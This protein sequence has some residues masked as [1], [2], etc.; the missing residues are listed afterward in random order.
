[1]YRIYKI[2]AD[3]VV[4]FAA[5][6]L[7]KYLRTM[8]PEYGE[9]S[10]E[11]DPDAK[12][13]FR[14][15]LLEDFGLPNEAPDS[16]MDDIVH[17]DTTDDGGILAGSNPRSVLFAVYRFLKLNGCRF[18][19]AGIDGEYIPH[20]P[21]T[22]QSYHKMADHRLRGHTTEGEP[23]AQNVMD[24][25][26]YHAK[27]ELNYYGLLGIYT[28]HDWHYRHWQN[29][30]HRIPEPVSGEQVE[31]WKGMM[32]AELLKRG[33][34][35][36]DGSH[37]LLAASIGLDYSEQTA[38]LQG[39]K[40]PTEEQISYMA[41]ING[42]RGLFDKNILATNMCMSQAR[43]RT[44][45]VKSL[46]DYAES[47][48]YLGMMHVSLADGSRNHCECPEC[49]KLRPSDF[50]IMIM[51]ELDEELT[52]RNLPIKISFSNYVDQ[53]FPPLQERIKNE[54][55]F[56]LSSAP[57]TRSYSSSIKEDTV[58]PPIKPYIR[59]NWDAPTT[60]EECAAYMKEWQKV[61]KGNCR[62]YEYHYWRPQ[63]MDPGLSYISRR[64]YEDVLSMKY[65]NMNACIQDGSNKS[66]FPHGFHSHIYSETLMNRDCDYEAE[67]EDYFRHIYGD[68]D[69]KK[70]KAYLDGISECF[71]EKYMNGEECADPEKGL[72]YNPA[73][74]PKLNQV[75]ELAA[76][77]RALALS[78][79]VMPTRPQTVCYRLLERHAEC[80]EYLA[81]IMIE[82]CQA[83]YFHASELIKKMV[84]E[85]GRYDFELD[86][87]FDF[88][89]LVRAFVALNYKGKKNAIVVQ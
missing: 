20:K 21:V 31:Q 88:G 16:T 33:M 70:V 46:A 42:K 59:N 50:L 35:L 83:H 54:D 74:V 87:Y 68:K 26:D 19:F 75:K 36:V 29:Q 9:I 64:V 3:H 71:G 39:K 11:Y 30:G 89:M 45:Y 8:M 32:E 63:Y 67:Q 25:I 57:I 24:Y 55:R 82:V 66:F 60:T 17:I 7:K 15:G 52:R 53:M 73:R 61:F 79:R 85:F 28:Y 80:V 38:Y 37:D 44:R 5:E 22:A 27:Q 65:L 48:Q 34:F 58:Y 56:Y 49:S 6:E 14:L 76:Q 81:D 13:G 41:M 43:F 18:L 77:A 2:R 62:M 86:R 40:E 78:H 84:K 72:Y 47:H 69:W 12:E 4:D 23:S 51:N 10:I 1:M